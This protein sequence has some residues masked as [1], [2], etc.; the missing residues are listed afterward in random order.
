MPSGRH[1][2]P[3]RSAGLWPAST[4]ERRSKPDNPASP[5]QRPGRGP[6]REDRPPALQAGTR[7]PFG[8]PASGRHRAPRGGRNQITPPLPH[9]DP[10]GAPTGRTGRRAFRPA[11]AARSERRPLAG[12]DRREA[13]ETR[14]PRLSLTATR[15]G[16]P[17]GGPAAVPSGRHPRPV[18]SAGLWPASTAERRSKPDNPASPSWR[19]GRGPHREDWPPVLQAGTRG[20]FGAPASGRHRPPRGGR[21][22]ATP[23]FPHGDPEGTAGFRPAAAARRASDGSRPLSWLPAPDAPEQHGMTVAFSW[24]QAT[25]R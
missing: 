1:P 10:E 17:P 8:A 20:P 23:L 6:H 5:S 25:I 16:P 13:V 4:A 3:V 7:G 12:I 22:Q 18:R 15:K 11:P 19:P 2:R 24:I 14:Q 21:N 9:S